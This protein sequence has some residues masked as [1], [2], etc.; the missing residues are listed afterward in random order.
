MKKYIL[1]FLFSTYS[2]AADIDGNYAYKGWDPYLNSNFTGSAVIT[3]VDNDVYNA[4][5]TSGNRK[6]TGTGI[7]TGDTLSFVVT[8]PPLGA[9]FGETE[10]EVFLTVYK[11][12]GS[13][14]KGNWLRMGKT[15][16]GT[17]ELDKR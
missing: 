7:K 17:E 9:S 5:W 4:E 13:K 10:M 1:F 14:L 16:L 3:K 12:S 15:L 6:Y 8:A 11:I 2:L